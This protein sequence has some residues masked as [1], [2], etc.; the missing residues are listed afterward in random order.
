MVKVFAR[1]F[2]DI[3][4]KYVSWV[5]LTHIAQL[6]PAENSK[7]VYKTECHFPE[8]MLTPQIDFIYPGIH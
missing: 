4:V 2:L 8:V 1:N 6:K 7:E 3:Q 5:I